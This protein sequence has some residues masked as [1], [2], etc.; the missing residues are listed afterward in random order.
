M[1][2]AQRSSPFLP[3]CSCEFGIKSGY[4]TSSHSIVCVCD[5]DGCPDDLVLKEVGDTCKCECPQVDCP[6]GATRDEETC[7]CVCPPCP[8]HY[9]P[10]AGEGCGCECTRSCDAGYT[11]NTT[12]CTCS[13]SALARESICPG[14][15]VANS[16]N[17]FRIWKCPRFHTHQQCS[18]SHDS[19]HCRWKCCSPSCVH[20]PWYPHHARVCASLKKESSCSQSRYRCNWKKC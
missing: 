19:F 10:T 8:T 12:S 4:I 16:R 14:K 3:P 11:L 5:P 18:N 15:C 2:L 13:L 7:E 1:Y 6:D 20:H 9:S 17:F